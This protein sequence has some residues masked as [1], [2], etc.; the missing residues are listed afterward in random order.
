[1][2][3]KRKRRAED[4]NISIE[5]PYPFIGEKERF[6]IGWPGYRTRPEKFGLGYVESVAEE[7]HIEGL[8]IR[9]LF[10]R[11]FRTRN[12][13]Y[14]AF[15]AVTGF[16]LML[17]LLF[18]LLDFF[19]EGFSAFYSLIVLAPISVFGILL[20]VNFFD[21]INSNSDFESITGI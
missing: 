10:T 13:I 14:L 15:M 8:C 6:L 5:N 18:I 19:Q 16:I 7:A 17:P 1:L 12:P 20:L 9:W 11:K 21:S 4:G 2:G 3:K